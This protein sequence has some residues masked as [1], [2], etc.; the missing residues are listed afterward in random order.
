MFPRG[1]NHGLWIAVCLLA[2][3]AGWATQK[4]DGRVV[5]IECDP[6]EARFVQLV[7][8]QSQ[9][10]PAIDELELYGPDAALNL[11]RLDGVVIRASSLIKG[12]AIHRIE[13]LNDGAYGNDH[14]WV[15]ADQ[16][17]QWVQVEWPSAVR[18]SRVVYSRDRTGRYTDRMPTGVEVRISLDGK[19]WKT[20]ADTCP[21]FMHGV[22]LPA[23]GTI[24]TDQLLRYAFGHEERTWLSSGASKTDPTT[25]ALSAMADMIERLA[26]KGVN[27]DAERAQLAAFRKRVSAAEAK[28]AADLF[29]EVRLA[30]RQL[31]LRDPDLA[32]LQ[33]IV[34]VKRHPLAASHNYSDIL[35][36]HGGGGGGIYMLNIPRS[37]DRLDPVN[38]DLTC[39]FDA[40]EGVVREAS[41]DFDPKRIYFAY[42]RRVN[43]YYHLMS[44]HADGSDL[45]QLTDGPFYDFDPCALPDGGVAFVSTRCAKRF[46]C[47]RPQAFVLFRMD[48]DGSNMQP[49]SFANLSEWAPSMMSDGRILWTRSEYIDKGADFGHTL[50]AIRPDGTYPELIFGNNT[51]Y[52]YANGREVPE[53]G[54]IV[55]ALMS[56]GGD[57]N[58][59]IALINPGE[60]GRYDADR[61]NIITPDSPPHFN[62][63][64]AKR[65]TFREPVPVSRDYFLVSHA[66]DDRFGLYVID[67]WGNR[68]VLYLDPMIGSMSAKPF[69]RRPTPQ[70][71]T[72]PPAH[73]ES[74]EGTFFVADVYAGLEPAVSR[75][76]V[77]YLRVV[78]EVPSTL[79]HMPDGSYRRDHESFL[80]WYATPVHK[81]SGPNGWPSYV[82]KADLGTTV[83]ESDGSAHFRVP[84]GRVLYFQ[85]LDENYNELQRMR[86]VVQLQPGETRGCIGCHESRSAAP[87]SGVTP[88]AMMREPEA[89]QAPPWGAGPF[90][91][92]R[93]VQPAWDARCVSCHDAKDPVNLTGTLDAEKV[94]ASYRTLIE[95][96]YVHYFDMHWNLRHHL[97][98]PR[99][100]GT[101][102]SPLI[103]LLE[104]GHYDVALTSD[105]M[106]A[107]KAWIDLNVPLWPDYQFRN[108]RSLDP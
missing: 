89:L 73:E 26:A 108:S 55:T 101:L 102:R 100:F 78:E 104:A 97:A 83:V 21:P 29:Y 3:S 105:Q 59:P 8:H 65:E 58:G 87:T 81:V 27:V 30:K 12:Y 42:R 82:A 47:W 18:L 62:M 36:A 23:N 48:A 99:S 5:T 50:W 25:R 64:W 80:D 69:V 98:Q 19:Q 37:G 77:K 95:K 35:D 94:P 40:G 32:S 49:L 96:G 13:H 1:L 4:T 93:V 54:E 16:R 106:R 9:G 7:I 28:A 85:A 76:Q 92:E 63:S 91:Y 71:V 86:S 31:M 44:I 84:A 51:R 17:D 79:Q 33:R 43:D 39:L 68:E 34:F 60:V 41:I 103:K 56:H 72:S 20:V 70:V 57:H 24:Q 107:I 45:R 38:A 15:A 53:T 46:L 11:A 10:A 61:V 88:L 2:A 75:G 52:C 6:A 22:A 90:S 67:R 14:S 74:A 66:P